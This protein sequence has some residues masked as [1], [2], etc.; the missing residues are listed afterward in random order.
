MTSLVIVTCGDLGFGVVR[1]GAL[2]R[3]HGNTVSGEDV[4]QL[5]ELGA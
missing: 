4:R 5:L 2:R 1:T 3:L